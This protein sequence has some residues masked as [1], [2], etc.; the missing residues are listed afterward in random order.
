MT[1]KPDLAW[2]ADPEVFAVNRL[3]AVSDHISYPSKDAATA[4]RGTVFRQSLNGEWSFHLASNVS[5]RPAEFFLR[6]FDVADWDRIAVP[7]YMQLQ[8]FG[9]NQ[10]VNTQYPWDGVEELRP[11]QVPKA[12]L[13]G[14]Y[15]RDFS[16]SGPMD[17]GRVVLTFDG[18]E[19]AFYVW[20]NGVFVG[21]G[22]DSFTP[23]RFD[24]TSL[25]EDGENRI[26]VQVFQRS[27]ASW[28]E[29]QDFWRLTGIFRDVWL[30]SQ[31]ALH[32]DDL[33]VTTDLSDDFDSAQLRLEMK[34]RLP[35]EGA[36]VTVSLKD[37]DG[38]VV[39][40]P[41][42][43]DAMEEMQLRFHVE[44]PD[45]WSAEAPNLYDLE[46][47]LKDASGTVVE[48]I[49]ERTGFRRFEMIDKVMHLNGKRIVFNGIN[50]HDFDARR[51]RAVTYEQMLWDVR[52][53]KQNNINAVRTC[54]YPN[55]TVFYR[56]CDEYGL[57]VIDEANLE[58]HGSWQKDGK[59]E[60]SWVVPGDNPQWREC[61]IDR[62]ISMVERDKNHPS[63]LIWSCGNEAYG[64]SVIYDMSNWF[65][66][67]DPSR[68]VHYEGVFHDRRYNDTSDMESRMYAKPQEVEAYL[69]DNPAKPFVLCEYMHAMG[70]SCGGMHLY[71]DLVDRYPLYQGGFIWD[72]IDQAIATDP[73]SDRLGYGGDFGDRPSDYE[74]SADGIV[75]A[76]REMTPK[77]QEVKGLYQPADI[78][79]DAG[80]ITLRNKNLFV[81]TDNSHLVWQLMLDGSLVASE[82][83]VVDVPAGGT[84]H[85]PIKLPNMDA[86]GE[87][88]LQAS[89]CLRSETLWAEAGHEVA[90]GETVLSA[91]RASKPGDGVAAANLNVVRGDL[92]F[93]VEAP[94]FKAM[95]AE[96]YG[97]LSSLKVKDYEFIRRP[98]RL[99]FWRAMTDNDRGRK[100]GFDL[101]VWQTASL[102]QK[103][104]GV[105]VD[106]YSNEPSVCYRFALPGLPVEP[107]VNYRVGRDGLIHVHAEY[108][109]A[110]GLPILPIFGM[111]FTMDA[112][113]DRFRYY[114]FGPDENY[115][116][117]MRGARL[118][119]FNGTVAGNLA[120]YL[121]PQESGN[122][123]GT[124]FAE[125]TDENGA[126]LRFEAE[127]APFEFSALPWNAFEL[128]NAL[129]PEELPP[130]YRTVITLAAKQMGVGG[131][132]SWGAPVHEPYLISSSEPQSLK[133]SI[134]P[135]GIEEARR[136]N[137]SQYFA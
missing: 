57:Y 70:N 68:L 103:I 53:F 38:R 98:P 95:F 45:L 15:V 99:T 4:G 112:R 119:I 94:G 46:I 10:Y 22:E 2:L 28:V 102:Y 89:L 32:L 14:S 47:V 131:D 116:D 111:Q 80:G 30:E 87:Y 97:G 8:G 115:C 100:H 39:I 72:Y 77:V 17:G 135:I 18:V 128:E 60:P 71:T 69:N 120:K 121:V 76:F 1:L 79:P 74:F 92:N 73:E 23:S 19:T 54:H 91:A 66:K 35:E 13:V 49:P 37:P 133:F 59:V 24:V 93:G 7:G 125:V 86:E 64:G 83:L 16:F 67:R 33:F 3:V 108:P 36:S 48:F 52:F 118:G 43:T 11:P 27:S 31:P 127:G 129:R 9:D 29:D 78:I 126:G 63:I 21:Y 61:V 107:I 124:R 117:R 110:E 25:I 55:Q 42:V 136:L 113:F 62:A 84:R 134:A 75:T 132:D 122:R 56:L 85:I 12:N 101:A 41:Q 82:E 65:R 51:G 34:L 137:P 114:G 6:N 26:A 40:A 88:V 44:K 104:V 109:G 123:M 5:T 106:A 58:S 96:V 90:F 50:R 130:V 81:S 20:L 105:E